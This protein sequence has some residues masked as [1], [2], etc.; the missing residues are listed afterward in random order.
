ML[1]D[2]AGKSGEPFWRQHASSAGPALAP[3]APERSLVLVGHSGAGQ[4]LP[5]IAEA[6]P[7]PV[8]A[9]LFVDSALP[10]AG[11]LGPP[12]GDFARGLR[13]LFEEGRSW[14]E[15][16]DDDLRDVVPGEESRRSLLAELQP[17]PAAFWEEE[18][19]VPEHWP[20]APCG[21]LLFTPAYAAEA[22]RARER[23][24]PVRALPGGHFHQLVDP[25]AV[26]ETLA[27]LAEA[28][29]V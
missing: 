23:G 10:G 15:W 8:Q 14:P 16:T 9:Y 28:K 25:D 17:R 19:P 4:L 18:I 13:G 24:W 20:D 3:V 2:D 21:Y 6:N 1:R 22:D 11:R 5:A 29:T 26:A 12:E 7:H 27:E